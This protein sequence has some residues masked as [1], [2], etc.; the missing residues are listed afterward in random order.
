MP[1]KRMPSKSSLKDNIRYRNP[2]QSVMQGKVAT[3][4]NYAD[5]RTEPKVS[6]NEICNCG[7]G[8]KFKKCCL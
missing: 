5:V 2:N 4:N 1:D 3:S 8:M 6:R 7:S